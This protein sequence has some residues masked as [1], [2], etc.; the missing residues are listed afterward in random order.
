MG[1]SA[2][3]LMQ[4]IVY[5]CFK[6]ESVG[7]VVWRANI[8]I[9]KILSNS[10][11][12]IPLLAVML[13]LGQL[14]PSPLKM[15]NSGWLIGFC[16]PWSHSLSLHLQSSLNGNYCWTIITCITSQE[17]TSALL[18]FSRICFI[19]FWGLLL[20]CLHSVRLNKEWFVVYFFIQLDL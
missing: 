11:I 15:I 18:M 7:P 4:N 3:K 14:R 2:C 10:C 1:I 13:Q 19:W 5:T 6:H 16:I 9:L 8:W 12:C 20:S 17:C